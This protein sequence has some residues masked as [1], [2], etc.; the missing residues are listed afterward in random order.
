MRIYKVILGIVLVPILLVGGCSARAW[1]CDRV[2]K[3]FCES[4]IPHIEWARGQSGHYP[5]QAD[6]AWWAGQSVPSLIR[7]E[8]FYYARGSSFEFWFQNDSWVFDNVL[9]FDSASRSWTSYDANY[10]EK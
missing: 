6:P 10:E 3:Q 1:Q 2:A 4:L 8:R 7:T 5:S 9:N